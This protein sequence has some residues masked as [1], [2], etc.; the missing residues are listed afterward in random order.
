MGSTGD[1]HPKAFGAV[2][3]LWLDRP[4]RDAGHRSH[5]YYLIGI[6]AVLFVLQAVAARFEKR[7]VWPYGDLQAQPPFGDLTGY[8]ARWLAEAVQAGFSFLGWAPDL[9]GDKYQVSYAM[10]ISPDRDSIAVIGVGSIWRMPLQGT[11]LHT[12]SADGRRSWYSTDNQACV[13]IDISRH[14]KSQLARAARFG[15]L[16]RRHRQWVERAGVTPRGFGPLHEIAEFRQFRQEHYRE[17]SRRGLISFTDSSETHWRYT[18]FGAVKW[19][20]LNYSIGLLRAISY[21]RLPRT[22]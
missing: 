9:K 10:V 5:M 16:W 17:M 8:G 19:A 4:L 6:V 18:L 7:M 1:S 20:V 22:A 11:W 3:H 14:W 12:P 21:G 15:E 13:E 2:V